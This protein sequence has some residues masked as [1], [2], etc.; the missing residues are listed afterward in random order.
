MR[1]RQLRIKSESQKR[2]YLREWGFTEESFEAA[3]RQQGGG[4][5]ICKK[6]N[7]SQKV[8]RGVKYV[9]KRRLAI[10]HDHATG[11]FRGILCD[12]CNSRLIPVVEH[13]AHLIP[14]AVAYLQRSKGGN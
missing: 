13:M 8:G 1:E 9:E 11:A 2:A 5:A 7:T 6:E 10:D 14:A 3:V 12:S 4:C